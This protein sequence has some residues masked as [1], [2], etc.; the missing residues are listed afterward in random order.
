VS[1]RMA[2]AEEAAPSAEDEATVKGKDLVYAARTGD[3]EEVKRLLDEGVPV[4]YHDGPSGWTPL[5]WAAS[6]GHEEVLTLLLDSDAAVAEAEASQ[7]AALAAEE[8]G[9]ASS[10]SPL[11]WAAYKGHV[12]L[13]WRLLTAKPKLSAK[14]L[15]GEL[16]TPLHCAAAGAHLKVLET[17]LGQGVDVTTR[18]AY[19]NLPVQL[20]TDKAC[21]ELLK[22]AAVSAKDGKYFLCACSRTFC[23]EVKSVADIVV[24]RVSAPNR[25]PVRYSTECAGDIRKAEDALTLAVKAADVP[26]L[27]EA[28][29]AANAIGASLPLIVDATAALERLKA[30]IAL[31]ESVNALQEA[32][33]LQ[34]RVL[35]R[36]MA[37]PIAKAKETGVAAGYISDAEALCQTAESEVVLWDLMGLCGPLKM[38]DAEDLEEGGCTEPPAA[39]S[40]VAKKA[41]GMI[42]KLAAAIGT[43]QSVEAMQETIEA[44]EL[45]LAYLTGEHEMRKALLLPKD[46]VTEEGAP[47]WTQHNGQMSYSVLEDLSFRDA[48]L[49]SSIEKCTAAGTAPGIL[50]HGAKYQKDLKALLKQAQIEED[51]RIAK[52]EAA[53]AKAAK[54]K[55]GKK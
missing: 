7:L 49:D 52:E 21:Q 51:E 11:H 24:D 25:R 41:E 14:E 2:D 43:A 30:Q 3:V 20:C 12:R 17:M 53:A 50:A 4:G 28:I 26:K 54:K 39:D 47:T 40:D 34:D 37:G 15:D 35:L 13:V 44:A 5:K 27:E 8:G 48:F 36:P 46:G 38:M 45:E 10:G 32:R 1:V 23:S 33:P 31:A 42:A 55:K 9:P 18:N 16:N 29:E 19:G 6:E 22:E